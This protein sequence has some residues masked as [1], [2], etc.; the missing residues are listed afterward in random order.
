MGVCIAGIVFLPV[1]SIFAHDSRISVRQPFHLF[2]PLE[3]YSIFPSM[4]TSNNSSY[5]VNI[6]FTAPALLAILVLFIRKESSLFLRV[7]VIISIIILAFPILGRFLNGMSYMTNRWIWAFDL[8]G[9]YILTEEWERLFKLKKNEY[10]KLIIFGTVYFIICLLADRS[11][12]AQTFAAIPFI[13]ISLI[14][15]NKD[16]GER[17]LYI[18]QFVMLVMVG[19]CSIN[20]GFW[21]YAPGAG[22]Y[23]NEF[24]E[25]SK[26]LDELKYDEL[27]L[28]N[29]SKEKSYTR[30][31]GRNITINSNIL[32]GISSTQFYWSIS[33]PFFNNYRKA[34]NMRE[35]SLYNFEGYDD[36][37]VPIELSSVDYFIARTDNLNGIPYGYSFVS[38]NN[39]KEPLRRKY[40]AKLKDEMYDNEISEPQINKLDSAL[41]AEYS[42]FK[43]DYAIPLG[44]CYDQYIAGDKYNELDPVQKQEVQLDAVYLDRE[45]S[46]IKK[47]SNEVDNYSIPYEVICNGNEISETDEGFVTTADNVTATISFNGLPNAETYIGFSGFDFEPTLKYDLYH[48]NE[49]VDPLNLYNKTNWDLLSKNDQVNLKKEKIFYNYQVSV[50]VSV[51]SSA[52]VWKTLSYVSPDSSFSSGRHDYI[53][54]LGYQSNPETQIEINFPKTGKYKLDELKVYAIPM[55]NYV[56]KISSLNEYT[57]KNVNMDVDDVRGTLEL[58][59][60]KILVMSIP[61]SIGWR[62]YVDGER[63]ETFVANERH[64]GIEVPKGN[65]EIEF[66]YSMPFKYQG[67]SLSIIGFAGVA[68]IYVLRKFVQK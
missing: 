37:T 8:L 62:A 4:F 17:L 28:V 30:I 66:K 34:L 14:V 44:Y 51:H 38:S 21:L 49:S 9:A 53:I 26:I 65:H 47:F 19:I 68:V 13:F 40:A 5:W 57:L 52:N 32:K 22:N 63:V 2:Y 20:L 54:N 36:R 3:Y 33:N 11:R 50:D 60:K 46:G 27:E 10:I 15:I 35:A 58:P 1:I 7:L 61:Y 23:V 41:N 42:L 18:K 25:N 29:K 67:L 64:V 59:E 55:D 43:N 39:I 48:G 16:E 24:M 45:H 56:Q 6:G 31:T 12:S